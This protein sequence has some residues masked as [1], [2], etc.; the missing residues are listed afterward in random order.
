MGVNLRWS[1]DGLAVTGVEGVVFRVVLK[2][3]TTPDEDLQKDKWL[4]LIFIPIR[5]IMRGKKWDLYINSVSFLDS[6]GRSRCY[7]DQR[8]QQ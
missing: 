2:A 7:Q 8:G 1:G 3:G 6:G 4:A 5:I